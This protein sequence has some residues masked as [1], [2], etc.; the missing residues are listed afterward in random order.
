MFASSLCPTER[1][2][3][4]HRRSSTQ[5]LPSLNAI[6]VVCSQCPFSCNA[7]I[8]SPIIF[9]IISVI[10]LFRHYSSVIILIK[11]EVV[12]AVVMTDFCFLG[13]NAVK[14]FENQ[15]TFQRNT[16][17]H[18]SDFRNKKKT[19]MKKQQ[20]EKGSETSIDFQRTTRRYIPEGRT[21][22]VG[23]MPSIM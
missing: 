12:T 16:S 17:S 15:S 1:F 4:F 10:C 7:L 3:T 19:S 2:S 18:Y 14:S 22:S 23:K 6:S 5:T 13:Y 8:A 9:S 21:R 20:A 11:R